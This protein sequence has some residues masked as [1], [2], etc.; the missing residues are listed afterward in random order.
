MVVEDAGDGVYVH[1]DHIDEDDGG[2]N[3]QEEEEEGEEEEEEEEEE[4]DDDDEKKLDEE[5]NE[6]HE[7][8]LEFASS[9]SS[10]ELNWSSAAAQLIPPNQSR[11]ISFSERNNRWEVPDAAEPS[12]ATLVSA[13]RTKSSRKIVTINTESCKYNVVRECSKKFGLKIVDGSALDWSVYWIDTG[14][15][16]QRILDM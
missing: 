1:N 9:S 5:L 15:S 3:D 7:E 10:P 12:R 14:V 11:T 4:E 16:V 6:Y 2:D 13:R 8:Q